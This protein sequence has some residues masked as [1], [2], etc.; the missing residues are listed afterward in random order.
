MPKFKITDG[1]SFSPPNLQ[2]VTIAHALAN[3]LCIVPIFEYTEV[4][5]SSLSTRFK[6]W[7]TYVTINQITSSI[8]KGFCRAPLLEPVESF[9]NTA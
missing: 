2:V 5:V 8:Q 9:I 3:L 7:Q 1:Y 4:V 6:I